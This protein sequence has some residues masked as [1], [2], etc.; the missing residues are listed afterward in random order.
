MCTNDELRDEMRLLRAEI[1]TL[2]ER[3]TAVEDRMEGAV[4]TQAD[5]RAA[6]TEAGVLK[7]ED[8]EAHLFTTVR[9]AAIGFMTFI[10]LVAATIAALMYLWSAVT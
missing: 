10:G 6:I 1:M 9:N 4:L 8:F 3:V 7:K 2:T 5:V